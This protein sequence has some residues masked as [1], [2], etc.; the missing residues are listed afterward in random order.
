MYRIKPMKNGS[1]LGAVAVEFAVVAPVLLAIA[2]GL[3]ELSRVYNAQNLLQTAAR[4]GARFA[5]M[6]RVGMLTG[7]ETANSKI[8]ND[9]KNYLASAGMDRDSIDVLIRD[10]NNPDLNFNLDDPANDLKLFDVTVETPYSSVSYTPVPED[11]D[12]TLTAS[13]TFRNGRLTY[14]E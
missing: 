12:Y 8:A 11:N 1:R 14:S 4:E 7:G 3:I 10:H 13:I 2:V 6:D 5:S 9:V